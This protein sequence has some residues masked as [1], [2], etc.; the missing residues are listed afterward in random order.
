MS[1]IP[2]PHPKKRTIKKRPSDAARPEKTSEIKENIAEW[3]YVFGPW[4]LLVLFLIAGGV[5]AVSQFFPAFF[6]SANAES[7]ESKASV[8]QPEVKAIA[9][10]K[11][12]DVRDL[13]RRVLT[14]HGGR[15]QL[16]G[17]DSIQLS[18]KL[19]TNDKVFDFNLIRKH[20]DMAMLKLKLD[21]RQVTDGVVNGVQW[22]R[23]DLEGQEPSYRI[24]GED[25]QSS[26]GK[27]LDSIYDPLLAYALNRNG[28]SGA[29]YKSTYNGKPTY[30]FNFEKDGKSL[31]A[32]IDMQTFLT[33]ALRESVTREGMDKEL[34]MDFSDYRDVGGVLIP[35]KTL[36]YLQDELLQQIQIE[37]ADVNMGVI[38]SLFRLPEELQGAD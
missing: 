22:R 14:A 17:I 19:D 21:S 26:W 4:I 5:F 11:V 34:L 6:E 1:K 36:L 18:G 10:T 24:I 38:S 7:D 25:E 20:P 23:I 28:Q 32:E 16:E 15:N 29:F 9:Q 12:E 3:T 27:N 37:R 33:L 8:V 35:F 30:L 2:H 31:Q 13:L